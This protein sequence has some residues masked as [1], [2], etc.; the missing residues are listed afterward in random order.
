MMGHV[1]AIYKTHIERGNQEA[2]I[3]SVNS[4]L[5]RTLAP[6]AFIYHNLEN[7]SIKYSRIENYGYSTVYIDQSL[8]Y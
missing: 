7:F 5:V 1:N 8:Q 4:V 2:R 3:L 6:L